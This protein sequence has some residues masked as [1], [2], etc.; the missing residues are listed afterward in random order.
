VYRLTLAACLCLSTTLIFAPS[1]QAGTIERACRNSDRQAAEPT[2]CRCIQKVAERR[3]TKS[4]QRTVAKWFADPHRAQE[5]R[6]S[7]RRS[8][9][10]L[11][12]RYKLFGTDA[13]R[14][15]G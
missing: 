9:A 13:E 12:E 7:D 11:W 6:Q 5:V 10:R 8:D 4:E 15:C 3:L 14:I 2:I 1:A